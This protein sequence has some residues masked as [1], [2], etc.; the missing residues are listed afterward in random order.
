MNLLVIIS[1][2]CVPLC[3]YCQPTPTPKTW[4]ST[5]TASFRESLHLP[6]KGS[7]STTGTWYY[8]W[9][10]KRFRI[11]RINGNLDRYCGLTKFL[12]NTPCT[13]YV[14]SDGWRYLSFPKAKLCCKCCGAQHGCSISKPNWFANGVFDPKDNM[15]D[16]VLV[17]TW[18]IQGVQENLYAET[19]DRSIPKRLFQDPESDMIFDEKTYS[20]SVDPS[21]FTIPSGCDEFCPSSSICTIVRNGSIM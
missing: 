14:D 6:G 10:T 11:D 21:L 4:S 18:S 7:G 19:K 8:D 17:N 9:T 5:W 16:G 12:T 15:I 20:E 13:Q 2:L 3:L 1:I